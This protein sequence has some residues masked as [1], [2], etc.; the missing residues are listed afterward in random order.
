LL[1]NVQLSL[2]HLARL[3]EL[4]LPRPASL[5]LFLLVAGWRS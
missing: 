4:E 3:I 5:T 2:A 1:L